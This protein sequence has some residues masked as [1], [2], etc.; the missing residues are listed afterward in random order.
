MVNQSERYDN[1]DETEEL[2]VVIS[3]LRRDQ[4]EKLEE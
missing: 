4:Q 3:G 1:S 2:K